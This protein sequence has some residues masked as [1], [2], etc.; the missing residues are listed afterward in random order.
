MTINAQLINET[1]EDIKIIN[2]IMKSFCSA[3]RYAFKRLLEN[4]KPGDIEKKI[5]FRYKLNIRYAKDAVK[6]AKELIKS[7]RELLEI[8]YTNA[9]SKV[10]AIEKVIRN[11]KLSSERRENLEN[12]LEKRKRKEA[13]YKSYIN[14]K[15]IPKVVFGSKVMFIKR[16][17]GLIT[18]EEWQNLRSN[19]V[20]SRGDKTKNWRNKWNR[21]QANGFRL[22]KNR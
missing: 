22:C 5:Y 9:K 17:K 16:C 4:K 8:N 12:R 6:E 2:E 10:K 21:L 11:K 1:S 15:T 14:Q 7:Q 18:N 20:Y 3:K 13:Y 19:R